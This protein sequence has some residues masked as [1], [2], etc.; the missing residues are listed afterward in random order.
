MLPGFRRR[1]RRSKPLQ[2]QLLPF[3]R[4]DERFH[5]VHTLRRFSRGG[6]LELV[7]AVRLIFRGALAEQPANGFTNL[8]LGFGP[9]AVAIGK[10]FP[11]EVFNRDQNVLKGDEALRDLFDRGGLRACAGRLCGACACHTIDRSLTQGPHPGKKTRDS[12]RRRIDQDEIGPRRGKTL[13]C[14]GRC[15]YLRSPGR[16]CFSAVVSSRMVRS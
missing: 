7:R 9:C 12:R 14:N 10:A 1:R 15:L 13:L 11:A 5:Q 2:L 6:D 4:R 3:Q 16:R 8:Q